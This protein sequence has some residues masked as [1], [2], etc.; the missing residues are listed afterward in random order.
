M[1]EAVLDI[2]RPIFKDLVS[3]T[4]RDLAAFSGKV[5]A[6][7]ASASRLQE[8]PSRF[9]HLLLPYSPNVYQSDGAFLTPNMDAP[10]VDL[11]PLVGTYGGYRS[12]SGD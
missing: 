3:Q 9:Q 1:S 12:D 2:E 10:L 11:A 7:A 5:H 6:Q 8:N 4:I